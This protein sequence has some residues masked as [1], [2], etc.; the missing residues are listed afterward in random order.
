MHSSEHQD[1]HI[2]QAVQTDAR[3]LAQLRWEFRSVAHGALDESEDVFVDRCAAWMHE[4]L[5]GTSTWTAWV[6]E[7]NGEV[8]GQIWVQLIE[9]L[10]NPTVE[11]ERH[12]Y[13][14]NLYVKPSARGG[15]GTRLL[16]R[17]LDWLADQSVHHIMLWPSRL[18]RS[19]Y[20]RHGFDITS[21]LL[22]RNG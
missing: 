4:R 3:Q 22:V 10:P 18:S 20:A 2:R 19:L 16:R 5:S 13:I 6:A 17:C 12:A 14:S 21:D 1:M 7:R 15:V 8:L 11:V 9:K